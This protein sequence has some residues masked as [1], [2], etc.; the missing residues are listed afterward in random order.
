MKALGKVARANREKVDRMRNYP[1]DEAMQLVKDTARSTFDETVDAAFNLGVDPRHADQMVRGAV[2]LPSGTGK[3]IRVVVFARGEKE[4]EARDA[5]ADFVGND[6]LAQKIL[7]GWLDFDAAI[8]TPDMMGVVGRLGRVLGPRGLMP[9]P[10]TGTVTPDVA[11]AVEESKAGKVEYRVNK[12]AGMHVPI[13]KASFT[14]EQLLENLAALM[15]AVVKARPAA[16][17]GTFV[18]KLHL[19]TT[20]GPGIRLNAQEAVALR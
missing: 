3:D 4:Q 1:L 6:D 11:K 16:A 12:E 14:E 18:R 9:N 13:G 8:A 20:M 10:R 17:K 7:D 2:V 5:G 15:D 19:S